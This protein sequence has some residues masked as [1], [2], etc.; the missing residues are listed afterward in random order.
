MDSDTS[1]SVDSSSDEL[2][3]PIKLQASHNSSEEE[4]DEDLLLLAI[5]YHE[6]KFRASQEAFFNFE[7]VP[8]N[9]N[10]WRESFRFTKQE[11]LFLTATFKMPNPCTLVTRHSASACDALCMFLHRLAYPTR[12]CQSEYFFGRSKT[13]VS[14]FFNHVLEWIYERYKHL[15]EW[16][17]HRL[18]QPVLRRF[19]AVVHQKGAPLNDCIGFID[20]TVREICKPGV[21]QKV[22][23]NGHKV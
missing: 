7:T 1:D 10:L 5:L 6:N 3:R 22:V 19:A 12:L 14:L 17:H 2:S 13:A 15:L 20:G 8:E 11:I 18:S 21:N 4:S 9:S 23:Y 16:D